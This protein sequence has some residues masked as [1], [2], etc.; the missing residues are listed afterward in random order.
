MIYSS[1]IHKLNDYNYLIKNYAKHRKKI[2]ILFLV[3]SILFLIALL[4]IIKDIT[5]YPFHFIFYLSMFTLLIYLSNDIKEI[6]FNIK[7]QKIIFKYGLF[8]KKNK[9]INIRELNEVSINNSPADIPNRA[10]RIIGKKYN[11]DLIDKELNA[12]RIYQSLDYTDEMKE[13]AHNVSKI[14]GVKLMDS[15]NVEGHIKIYKKLVL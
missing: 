11:V 4:S 2:A 5:N 3:C 1:N 8:V 6:Y 7:E 15:N 12:Y 14:I 9:E 10:K 13:F